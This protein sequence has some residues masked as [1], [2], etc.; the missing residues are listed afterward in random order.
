MKIKPLGDRVLVKPCAEE[1]KTA[2]GIIIPDVAQEKTQKGVV[3][4]IGNLKDKDL[5]SEGQKFMHNKYAGVS[6][7][8]DDIEHL[9]V[10]TEDLIAIIE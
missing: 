10:K 1:T 7:K 3:V 5:I 4:A 9:L 8:I 2:G 6:V